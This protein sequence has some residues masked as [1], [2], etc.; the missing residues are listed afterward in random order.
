MMRLWILLAALAVA[1]PAV[2]DN[3]LMK[4]KGLG[5]A[6]LGGVAVDATSMIFSQPDPWLGYPKDG[7]LPFSDDAA[8]LKFGDCATSEGSAVAKALMAQDDTP[9]KPAAPEGV[10]RMTEAERQSAASAYDSKAMYAGGTSSTCPA[11]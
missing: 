4:S 3:I 9:R 6:I 11:N 5:A 7:G 2:A 10:L 8:G 1:A